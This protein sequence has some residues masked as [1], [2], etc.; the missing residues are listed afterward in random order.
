MRDTPHTVYPS[1]EGERER[2]ERNGEGKGKPVEKK[3]EQ[4]AFSSDGPMCTVSGRGDEERE[5][6]R[7]TKKKHTQKKKKGKVGKSKKIR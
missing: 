4:R 1:K 6:Q 3:N 5:I 7:K 2:R